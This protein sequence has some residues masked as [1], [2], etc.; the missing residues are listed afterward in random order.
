M[1]P[2]DPI[3]AAIDATW[4]AASII[5]SGRFAVREG[6]GG[7]GR[8]S[9]ASLDGPFDQADIAAAEAAHRAFGQLPRFMIRPGEDPLDAALAARGYGVVDP[10]AAYAIPV[11]LLAGPVPPV[12]AFAIWPPLQIT[13]DLWSESGIGAERQAVMDRVST[14]KTAILGRTDDRCAGA[15]FV[16][17]HQKTAMVHALAI[18]PD[19]RRRGLARHMMTEAANWAQEAGADTLTLVVTRANVAANALYRSL[20]MTQTAAYHYRIAPAEAA[21]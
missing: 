11:A 9:A 2:P 20:G 21:A 17:L 10:V 12:T 7:G 13:R 6:R 3:F 1:T 19:L 15:A 14:P 4:P 16:A 5:H 8:V 18:L